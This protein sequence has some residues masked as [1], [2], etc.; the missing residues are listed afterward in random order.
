MLRQ[1]RVG[2]DIV[3]LSSTAL[4]KLISDRDGV[5]MADVKSELNFFDKYESKKRALGFEDSEIFKYFIDNPK[6]SMRSISVRFGKNPNYLRLE[7]KRRGFDTRKRGELHSEY[8][9]LY[10][11]YMKSKLNKTEV[12]EL[13]G[14]DPS[15]LIAYMKRNGL[16]DKMDK[17]KILDTAQQFAKDVYNYYM[18]NVSVSKVDASLHFNKHSQYLYEAM[19]RYEWEDKDVVRM[20]Y[21]YYIDTNMKGNKITMRQASIDCGMKPRFLSNNKNRLEELQNEKN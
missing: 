21:D 3:T 14:K 8:R 16:V 13:F 19:V 1:I 10:D 18:T 9:E 11:F 6:E 7:L 20:V 12:C 4:A 17:W 2:K 5:A 15:V